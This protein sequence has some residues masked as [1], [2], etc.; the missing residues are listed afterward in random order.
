MH[1]VLFIAIS[2]VR[3]VV[4]TVQYISLLWERWSI[5]SCIKF[6][7]HGNWRSILSCIQLSL[8]WKWCSILSCLYLSNVWERWFLLTVYSY[9]RLGNW[10]PY[11]PVYI[12]VVGTLVQT[13]LCLFFSIVQMMVHTVLIIAFSVVETMVHTVV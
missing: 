8:L 4:S 6:V 5:L 7:C 13:V 10:C 12:F 3:T 11:C 1:T 9:F 2:G